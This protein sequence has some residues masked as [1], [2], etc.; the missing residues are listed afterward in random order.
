MKTLTIL[1]LVLLAIQ[2]QNGLYAQYPVTGN[3][4]PLKDIHSPLFGKDIVIH[5]NSSQD[6]RQVVICSAFNG[7][8]YAA[9]TY[10]IPNFQ[11]PYLTMLK[12]TDDGI[13]W[14]ILVDDYYPLLNSS[15]TSIDIVTTGDSLSNLKLFL[16]FVASGT[17]YIN[18]YNGV[19]G[20]AEVNLFIDNGIYD[21]AL[22]SDF[23]T[24]AQNSN[25]NS[26]GV[27]CS[28]NTN[29]SDS[30]IFLSSSNGG[31]SLDGH[32]V[33]A[34]STAKFHKVALAYGRSPSFSSG[35]YYATWEERDGIGDIPGRIFTAH[36]NPNFNSPFTTP[37]NLDGIDPAT[38]NLC[39]NPTIACQC[40]SVDN[41][42]SNITEIVMFEKFKP[43]TNQHDIESYFNKQ[44]ASSSHFTK[45]NIT[46][47][48]HNNLQPS[49]IFNPFDSTFI[50]TYF[51][52]TEK[53]LPYLK[54]NFNLQNPN[55]WT[56]VN[57]GYNDSSNISYPV[58]EN[59]IDYGQHACLDV[60][61]ADQTNGNGVALFDASNSVYTGFTTDNTFSTMRNLKIY[62]NPCNTYIYI[63][64]I[65]QNENKITIV[66]NDVIGQNMNKV[67]D[68]VYPAGNN[69]V[70]YNVSSLTQGS[71]I[72]KIKI[73]NNTEMKKIIVLR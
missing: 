64:F 71:Y 34:I 27:L 4:G 26:L 61:I 32:Q 62:P 33:V 21:I 57:T 28:K 2:F 36:S 39:K 40:N 14:S 7:W 15:F 42:S 67:V 68:K 13:T 38:I 8:L 70:L 54:N 59:E 56:I 66:L 37:V 20:E 48:T 5:D 24:P 6:Q 46:D 35:R 53:E 41:D 73:G 44:S 45:L 52:S 10:T 30:I 17:A 25:P 1:L 22:C 65:L 69:T 31:L 55:N 63:N 58:P 9:L 19:S 3:G 18:R 12:S 29:F 60:W 43:L 23:I 16:S 47:S 50:F 72:C 49:L 51:D 11:Y